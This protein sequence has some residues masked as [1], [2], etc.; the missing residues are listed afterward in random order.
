MLVDGSF[1]KHSFLKTYFDS[2]ALRMR[3]GHFRITLP[4]CQKPPRSVTAPSPPPQMESSQEVRLFLLPFDPASGGLPSAG[5]LVGLHAA[6]ER[7]MPHNFGG[8]TTV[9]CR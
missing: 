6:Y 7:S 9:V 3:F 8:V 4:C 2:R 5:A 1:D